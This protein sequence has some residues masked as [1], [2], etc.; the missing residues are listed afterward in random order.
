[1]SHKFDAVVPT[2][3]ACIS[4]EE[5]A[6]AAAAEQG[7]GETFFV[8]VYDQHQKEIIIGHVMV[9]VIYGSAGATQKAQKAL[10]DASRI[11]SGPWIA[12]GGK[13]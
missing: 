1:M 7:L 5:L 11:I 3:V 9:A 12:D 8:E 4:P 13:S 2:A 10:L 6:S